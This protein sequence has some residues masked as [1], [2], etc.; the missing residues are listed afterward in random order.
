M[1]DSLATTASN[2]K[3]PIFS[4]KKFEIHVKHR[5]VVPANQRYWQ[6]FQDDDEIDEFLQNEGKFKDTS[7]DVEYD[8]GEVDIEVNQMEV[9]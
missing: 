8:D 2:F 3:I 7:I 1:V 4:N 6:V 5:P 9:L